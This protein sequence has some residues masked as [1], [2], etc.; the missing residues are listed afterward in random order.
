[1]SHRPYSSPPAL[2]RLVALACL[3]ASVGCGDDS[4][5]VGGASAVGAGGAGGAGGAARGGAP[6]QGGGGSGG[7]VSIGGMGGQGGA[8][9]GGAGGAGGTGSCDEPADAAEIVTMGAADKVLLKGMVV[10]PDQA[11]AGEVLVVGDSL[12]CVAATCAGV[13][14]A[15]GA[16]VV[17]THGIILP[18]LVDVHNHILFDIFDENDWAPTQ[19]YQNHNQWV[20]DPHYDAM[21]DAKQYLNS[22]GASPVELSCELDKYGELK[23]LIAGSTTIVGHTGT[24][25]SCY[26]TLARTAEQPSNGL[27]ADHVQVSALFPPSAASANGV[28]ANFASGATRAYLIH[29]GEGVD[30]P[31]KAELATL[32]TVTTP[33][34]CL[35]APQTTLVHATAFGDAELE[36]MAQHGMSLGWSSRVNVFLYGGGTD[37]TKNPDIPLALSKGINVALGPDW[38]IGGSQNLLD[39]LRYADMVDDTE[40]GDQISPQMLVQM[41]TING[42]KA[43]GLDDVLGSLAPGKKADLFVIGGDAANP[44]DAVL[45]ATPVD[46]RLVM[47]GGKALYGD[48]SLAPLGPATPGCETLDVCCR[49]K[50]ACVAAPSNTATDKFGQTYVEIEAALAQGLADYDALGLSQWTFSPITPLVR[51]E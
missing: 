42:A 15:S 22:E 44:Y 29:C 1:M 14:E 47:V 21:L 48:P 31:S 20:N 9:S 40:W 36:I 49:S 25:R 7:G 35:F 43:L 27:G 6:A 18:G 26:G 38:S 24:N 2:R 3:S 19:S 4:Q 12:A 30:A 46:V 41:A 33:D 50:F 32:G 10:T 51:C 45:A 34:E 11:F 16:T 13:P 37:L 8:A 39:E 17:D 23:G 5:S 28:C